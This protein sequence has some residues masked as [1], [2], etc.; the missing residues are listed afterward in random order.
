MTKGGMLRRRRQGKMIRECWTCGPQLLL[1]TLCLLAA[2]LLTFWT[3]V[4]L[5]VL[6]GETTD[7]EELLGE[8]EIQRRGLRLRDREHGDGG[9]AKAGGGKKEKEHVTTNR[10]M[11]SPAVVVLTHNRP[12]SLSDCLMQ[13]QLLL[14]Q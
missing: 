2:L 3:G 9:G 10:Q 8:G 14:F 4:I 11:P 7:G 1:I 6:V 5:V 12:Q 13:D